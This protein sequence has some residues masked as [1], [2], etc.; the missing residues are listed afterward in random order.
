M[1]A[2]RSLRVNR[3]YPATA[4]SGHRADLLRITGVCDH[5]ESEMEAAHQARLF[6]ELPVADRIASR[7]GRALARVRRVTSAAREPWALGA[8]F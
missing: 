5:C 1:A 2:P 6:A 8:P 3:Y 7:W 4:D